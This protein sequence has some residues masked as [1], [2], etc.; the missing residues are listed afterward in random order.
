M[1]VWGSPKDQLPSARC[2]QGDPVVGEVSRFLGVMGRRGGVGEGGSSRKGALNSFQEEPGR[3]QPG[4]SPAARQPKFAASGASS[5]PSHR[6][7]AARAGT[8]T[9]GVGAG[10]RLPRLLGSHAGG[11]GRVWA[12]GTVSSIGDG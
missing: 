10:E 2:L 8:E 12:L 5:W 4:S 11:P 3:E 7:P 9:A 6:H 1:G